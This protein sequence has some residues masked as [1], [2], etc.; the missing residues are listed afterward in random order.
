M[1][2]DVRIKALEHGWVMSQRS[3]KRL[4]ANLYR[5]VSGHY[6]FH[7]SIWC[8]ASKLKPR[9]PSVLREH[10]DKV[11]GIFW[12]LSSTN[13]SKCQ[14]KG[15]LRACP[16]LNKHNISC[17]ACADGLNSQTDLQKKANIPDLR[18]VDHQPLFC[19]FC[20]RAQNIINHPC[21]P[22][23][24]KNRKRIVNIC[25]INDQLIDYLIDQLIR[26]RDAMNELPVWW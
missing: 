9:Q 1:T 11:P 18:Y 2:I 13:T 16:M 22:R 19:T 5:Y 17:I 24:G 26:Y 20:A 12:I 6:V 15:R 3:W 14:S 23:A 10:L 8:S 4:A 21:P 7:L 25:F